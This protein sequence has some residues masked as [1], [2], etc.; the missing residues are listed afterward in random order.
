MSTTLNAIAIDVVGQYSEAAHPWVD[1][2]RT[3]A[4]RRLS[5][6]AARAVA[7]ASDRADGAID[8]ASSRAIESMQAFG[9]RTSWANDLLVVNALRTVNLPAAR[10]SLRVASQVNKASSRLS[11]RVAGVK[12]DESASEPPKA[13]ARKAPAKRA[14]RTARTA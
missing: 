3:G 7:I 9:E 12:P 1:A 6:R 2:W 14:R 8:R 4:Q 11:Q 10:L 13:R 5:G